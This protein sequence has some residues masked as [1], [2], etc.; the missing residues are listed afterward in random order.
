MTDFTKDIVIIIPSYKPD[1]KLI[2]VVDGVLAKGFTDILVVNDGSGSDYDSVFA[3]ATSAKECTLLI[4]EVNRGKGCAMKT[5][6]EYCIKHRPNCK[7]VITV[8]GDNQHHPEDIATCAKL[9]LEHNDHVILGARDFSGPDV[10]PRSF[11]GNQITR[12]VFRLACGIKLKDTQTGLRAFPYS[13]LPLMASIEGERYEYETNVLLE[14][15]S[16]NIPFME[17]M[18]RTIYIEENNSSHFNAVRDSFRIYKIIFKFVAGSAMSSIID[19]ALFYLLT[20][21]L[22]YIVP[23]WVF[24]ILTATAIARVCSSIFNYNFNRRKVFKSGDRHSVVRYYTLCVCQLL[25][26]AGLVS[27]L[28]ALIPGGSLLTTLLKLCVDTFLFFISYQIQRDWVFK[29]NSGIAN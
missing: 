8:D 12:M 15:K 3:Q 25:A 19:I 29:N 21:L 6:Y 1:G 4:H 22:N 28:N 7:G 18:I 20:L 14:M 26:S 5:A 27:L 23:G 13:M 9:V 2:E 17:T 10:P 24:S 16:H 11:M